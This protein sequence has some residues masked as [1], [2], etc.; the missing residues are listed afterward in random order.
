MS[1]DG[2]NI[3]RRLFVGATCATALFPVRAS[4]DPITWGIVLSWIAEAAVKYYAG[5]TLGELFGGTT[6]HSAEVIEAIRASLAELETRLKEDFRRV[7]I[8][9]RIKELSARVGATQTNLARY[10]NMGRTDQKRNR[11]LL[12]QCDVDTSYGSALAL[13][14]GVGGLP[15]YALFMCQRTI[16]MKAFRL[17]DHSATPLKVYAVELRTAADTMRAR[18]AEYDTALNPANRLSGLV[19]N[20][21]SSSGG[22]FGIRTYSCSF[23]QDGVDLA[24]NGYG[25]LSPSQN[26]QDDKI[27]ARATDLLTARTAELAAFRNDQHRTIIDPLG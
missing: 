11:A 22:G 7:I 25:G 1:E 2:G 18:L 9:D 24:Q 10:A 14:Y 21:E 26:N 27:R 17:A 4:A 12:A 19:C 3:S 13:Q 6:D 16:V 23:K 15:A 20:E 8:D 5:K